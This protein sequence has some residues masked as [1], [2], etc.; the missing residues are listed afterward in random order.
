MNNH[1]PEADICANCQKICMNSQILKMHS[2]ICK[3]Y[4]TDEVIFENKLAYQHFVNNVLNNRTGGMIT[5]NSM[6][7]KTR[8]NL[9]LTLDNRDFDYEIEKMSSKV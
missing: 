3:N 4:V 9:K 5:R 7:K 6:S 2:K 8:N 1:K